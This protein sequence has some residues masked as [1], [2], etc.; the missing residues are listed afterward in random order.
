MKRIRSLPEFAGSFKFR[1]RWQR[2]NQHFEHAGKVLAEVWSNMS[3][4]GQPIVPEFISGAANE[5]V[6]SKSEK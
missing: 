1:F 6:V 2:K 5:P 3:F 4:D